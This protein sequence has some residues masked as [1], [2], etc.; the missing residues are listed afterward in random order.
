MLCLLTLRH[1]HD[2]RATIISRALETS[3]AAR[4]TTTKSTSRKVAPV[5]AIGARRASLQTYSTCRP[6]NSQ[7]AKEVGVGAAG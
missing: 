2:C 1:Q 3:P 5:A 7:N 6:P 4:G